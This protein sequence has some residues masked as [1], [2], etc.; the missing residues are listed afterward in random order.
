MNFIGIYYLQHLQDNKLINK[1][2]GHVL[3]QMNWYLVHLYFHMSTVYK[4]LNGFLTNYIL[5]LE[6]TAKAKAVNTYY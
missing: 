5:F 3:I 1:K 4:I 6:T 2:S